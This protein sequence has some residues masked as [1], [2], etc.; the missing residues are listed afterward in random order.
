MKKEELISFLT[1]SNI[2]K[3]K[4]IMDAFK[5]IDRKDF[6]PKKY[7]DDAY[8]DH[9]LDIG[10]GQTISQPSTVAFM[11]ELLSPKKGEKILDVGSGSGWTSALLGHIVGDEGIVYGVEIVKDLVLFGRANLEK[12]GFTNVRIYQAGEKLGL[13]EKGLFDRILVSAAAKEIP[14]ELISQLKTGGTL[15]IPIHDSIFR[16]IKKNKNH[17]EKEKIPGFAFVPLIV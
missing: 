14:A 2:L 8:I 13:K 3:T 5:D 17:L 15:V 6:V 7:V 11:L 9:P 4:S 10:F 12:Y 1:Q 16:I